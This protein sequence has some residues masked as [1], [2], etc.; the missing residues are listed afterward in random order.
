MLFKRKDY[1]RVELCMFWDIW[2]IQATGNNRP[3]SF[4]SPKVNKPEFPCL[5]FKALTEV[6]LK[7]RGC[8]GV[9]V[10]KNI[11]TCLFSVHNIIR[12]SCHEQVRFMKLHF[13]RY[14][15]HHGSD[16][17]T[18][19]ILVHDAIILLYYI[20]VYLGHLSNLRKL[21]P[22]SEPVSRQQM[23]SLLWDHM[24]L[25]KSYKSYRNDSVQVV[26]GAETVTI[27]S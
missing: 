7:P 15:F 26:S 6:L 11:F 27:T 5:N 4:K 2:S 23:T 19:N 22:I 18:S 14:F 10:Y 9:A 3:Y 24:N 16:D 20:L 17:Q 13:E 8:F 12:L 25:V 21:E 1:L